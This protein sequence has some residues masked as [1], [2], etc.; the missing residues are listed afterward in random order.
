MNFTIKTQGAPVP[1]AAAVVYQ[2]EGCIV[3]ELDMQSK[4][5][6]IEASSGHSVFIGASEHSLRLHPDKV[7]DEYTIV[8]FD[9]PPGKWTYTCGSGGRYTLTMCFLKELT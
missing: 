5:T 1:N 9:L 7:R 3:I 8:E 6:S 2:S 4:Y